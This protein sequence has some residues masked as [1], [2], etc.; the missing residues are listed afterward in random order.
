MPFDIPK[1]I[2]KF[3]RI[4]H[5]DADHA[6]LCSYL[7]AIKPRGT[8]KKKAKIP[9]RSINRHT[10]API[11]AGRKIF[12]FKALK[13]QYLLVRYKRKKRNVPCLL[14]SKSQS[15]LVLRAGSGDTSWEYF[16]PFGNKPAKRIGVLVVNF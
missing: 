7:K 14:D 13:N 2:I 1:V 3:P 9:V 6:A 16:P 12:L 11:I 4:A 8:R 5:N 15:S 10:T